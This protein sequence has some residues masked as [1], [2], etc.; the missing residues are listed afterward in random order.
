MR[1][2]RDGL[3]SFYFHPFLDAKLLD[4]VVAGVSALGY[5]FVSLREFGGEVEAGRYAVRT[6]SGRVQLSPH[7]E[8]W[9]MRRFDA[10]GK[11]VNQQ[12]SS[13]R[14]NTPVDINVDVPAGG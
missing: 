2:V 12:T 1:V 5:H 6:Q 8:N 13:A 10:A 9:R 3:P 11:M 14:G 7:A 4:Q